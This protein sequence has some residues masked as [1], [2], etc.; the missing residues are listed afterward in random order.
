MKTAILTRMGFTEDRSKRTGQEILWAEELRAFSC[1]EVSVAWPSEW[2]ADP[3]DEVYFL[4]RNGIQRIVLIGYSYGG[5][6]GVQKLADLAIKEGLE[7]PLMLL[8]DPVY[9]PKWLPGWKW[10]HSPRSLFP[11]GA[12][13]KVNPKV[14]RVSYVRQEISLPRAHKVS[15]SPGTVLGRA[16]TLEALHTEIDEAPEWRYMVR[17]ELEKLLKS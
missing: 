8:C 14:G 10:L 2:N 11:D 1:S 6:Y 5:G 7:V 13:I 12:E 17:E 15:L 16:L 9:R 3:E 4:K